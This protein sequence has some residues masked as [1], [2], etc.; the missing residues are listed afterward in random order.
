MPEGIS[1]I[2]DDVYAYF[3]GR[4]M[5]VG[6]AMAEG[7]QVTVPVEL[8]PHGDE[9]G[10]SFTLEYDAAKLG[11][12]RVALGDA[13]PE[14]ATLTFNTN[15]AGR[16]GVLVDS[17]E[18]MTASAMPKRIVMVTFDVVAEASGDASITLT[19][20]L[21]AKG[22]SNAAGNTLTVRYLDGVINIAAETK[23]R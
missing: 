23:Q 12:P 21:A 10:V 6:S 8:T 5:R 18:A 1:S 11:N 16:I 22:M 2:I 9:A 14:G 13:A 4:E 19:G 3:F 17:T 7:T 20:T 15:E